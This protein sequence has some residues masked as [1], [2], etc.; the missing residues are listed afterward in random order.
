MDQSMKRN[1]QRID[2]FKIK[3]VRVQFEHSLKKGDS[4][5][6]FIFPEFV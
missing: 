6:M 2:F 5:H 3:I 1:T 4:L